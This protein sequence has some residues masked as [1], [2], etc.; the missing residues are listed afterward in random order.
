M[1][2]VLKD[3]VLMVNVCQNQSLSL[4]IVAGINTKSI[5]I[6][7][8]KPEWRRTRSITQNN[9]ALNDDDLEVDPNSP[10]MDLQTVVE[11]DLDSDELKDQGLP[12]YLN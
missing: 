3:Y 10:L 8:C 7:N 9:S 12:E 5:S 6:L 1:K 4:N 11:I 2:T